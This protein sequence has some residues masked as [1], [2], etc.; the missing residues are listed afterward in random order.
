VIVEGNGIDFEG[1]K[2]HIAR[3]GAVIHSV[4]KVVAA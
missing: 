2:E 3:H 4:D 1:L